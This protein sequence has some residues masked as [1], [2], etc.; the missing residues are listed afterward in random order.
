[1][2]KTPASAA[3]LSNKAEIDSRYRYWRR[4]I[5]ITIWLGY[6]LFYFTRKSFNAAA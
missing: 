5:L 6:A 2:F 4:H 1:M 3:P